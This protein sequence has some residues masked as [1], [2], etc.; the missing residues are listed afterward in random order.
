MLGSPTGL[1]A[2]EDAVLLAGRAAIVGTAARSFATA[3]GLSSATARRFGGATAA[4]LNRTTAAR[5]AARR[6]TAVLGGQTGLQAGEEAALLR[7]TTRVATRRLAAAARFDVAAAWLGSATAA[8]HAPGMSVGRESQRHSDAQ[9]R[10]QV[11]FHREAPEKLVGRT[12][13][14]SGVASVV[15]PAPLVRWDGAK[16]IGTT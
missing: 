12:M 8:A 10:Q 14:A 11:T 7:G 16:A 9:R 6:S 1:D 2:S 4:R 15:S 5:F 3:R 13:V